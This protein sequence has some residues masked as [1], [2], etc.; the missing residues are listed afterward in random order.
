VTP[1]ALRSITRARLWRIVAGYGALI[2]AIPYFALKIVWLSG[3]DLGAANPQIMRDASMMA[4]NAITAVMD[5]VGMALA[6]AFVHRW[7][8]RVPSWLLLTPMWVASGLLARFVLLVP[9]A[10]VAGILSFSS[11]TRTISGPVQ[12]W[13]YALV[14][15]E[16]AGM[17][18]GLIVAFFLYARTRWSFIVN[19]AGTTRIPG[20]GAGMRA[21]SIPLATAAA[22]LAVAVGMLQLAWAMGAT[23][24][25][26]PNLAAQRTIVSAALNLTDGAM[27][28]AGAAGLLTMVFA[29][30]HDLSFWRALVPAWIGSASMF[31][32]GLWSLINV[33]GNT[34]LMRERAAAM[35][36]LNLVALVQL[37]AGLVAG[38]VMLIALAE[39]ARAN[40]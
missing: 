24:G 17:G 27:A 6:L 16:F 39:R 28:I 19:V 18:F 36:I 35:V 5:V 22:V 9:P 31:S 29:R 26:Q 2:C 30:R 10:A 8:L 3:G 13:V 20:D 25:L 7:G 33:L 32:W 11:T 12:P 1:P 37:I 21:L 38:I 4:L 15:T 40:A 23:F 14:Y 34:A